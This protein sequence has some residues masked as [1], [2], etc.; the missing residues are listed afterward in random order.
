MEVSGGLRQVRWKARG[1]PSQ[2]INS[3]PSLHSAHSS[4]L[5]C[6]YTHQQTHTVEIRWE[7]KQHRSF[8]HHWRHWWLTIIGFASPWW[9]NLALADLDFSWDFSAKLYEWKPSAPLM[10]F[11]TEPV[12]RQY[13]L[14]Q[15]SSHV[16]RKKQYILLPIS[17][18]K[19]TCYQ[20]VRS[21]NAIK[22][23]NQ[24]LKSNNVS[25]SKSYHPVQY[26]PVWFVCFLFCPGWKEDLKRR[27]MKKRKGLRL[28]EQR[29][30]PP[31]DL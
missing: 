25:F 22:Q 5:E 17:H 29:K 19:K 7:T 10:H 28:S 1:Q 2:Q 9:V 8:K 11:L 21:P 15:I 18:I 12:S 16:D 27:K 26:A 20:M 24:S 4:S 13:C 6:I 30:I 23:F 14:P 31:A 3:P